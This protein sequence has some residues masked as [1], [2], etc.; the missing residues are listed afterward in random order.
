ML[1]NQLVCG[2]PYLIEKLV[3]CEA[4]KFGKQT[5]KPFPKSSWRTSQ[6]L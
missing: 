3:E 1:K 6:E 5:R 4:C 2:V